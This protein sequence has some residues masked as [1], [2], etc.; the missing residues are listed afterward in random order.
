MRHECPP[1][2]HHLGVS[3]TR[4]GVANY[5]LYIEGG[6]AGVIRLDEAIANLKNYKMA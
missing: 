6:V 3:T 2:H 4:V 1:L 5:L